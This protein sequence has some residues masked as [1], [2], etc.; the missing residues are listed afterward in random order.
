MMPTPTARAA[1]LL[2]SV[3]GIDHAD[4]TSEP[5]MNRPLADQIPGDAPAD[6]RFQSIDTL[7][8]ELTDGTVVLIVGQF[9][10]RVGALAP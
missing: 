6:E 5:I 7:T 4:V 1:V 3:P 2:S 8:L 10:V 9:E